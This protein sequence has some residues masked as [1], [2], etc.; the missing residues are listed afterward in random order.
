MLFL[1]RGD[2][3]TSGT[4]RSR[5]LSVDVGWFLD[6]ETVFHGCTTGPGERFTGFTIGVDIG[7]GELPFID[8]LTLGESDAPL[9]IERGAAMWRA[10]PVST[11]G[12]GMGD[13]GRQLLPRVCT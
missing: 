12:A 3:E 8:N 10:F 2:L 9:G 5:D 1:F 7:F 6:G 13:L 4:I 11:A